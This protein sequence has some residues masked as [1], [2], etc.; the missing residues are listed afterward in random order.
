M[1]IDKTHEYLKYVDDELNRLW[2]LGRNAVVAWS[3]VDA[4]LEVLTVPQYL[5][6]NLF[7]N[8]EEILVGTEQ[9]T[10]EE[11]AEVA[12]ICEIEP[13]RIIVPEALR[14]CYAGDQSLE[15]LMRR[16]GITKLTNRAVIL[17]DIVGFSHYSP[18]EQVTALNSLSYSIN[19]AYQRAIEHGLDVSLCYSTTGDGFYVW[20]RSDGLDANVDVFCFLMLVLADNSLGRRKGIVTTIPEL[21]SG[22]NIGDC[23]EYFQAEGARPGTGSYIVGDA[24][25]EL[26]R[27]VEKA[28]PYQILIGDFETDADDT[29]STG[30]PK[31]SAPR[32]L[33]LA[34]ARLKV[35]ENVNLSRE[36]V[37]SIK[38]YLTGFEQDNGSY[39]VCRYGFADKHGFS[40]KVYNA[41]V[42]VHRAN[43]SEIF[44]GRMTGDLDMFDADRIDVSPLE[45]GY[46]DILTTA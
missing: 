40:H 46:D 19:V 36:K 32:F 17:F 31:Y 37:A 29:Q 20:N 8:H 2:R 21:R 27:I 1:A 35:F 7:A 41:K 22:F 12:D 9:R 6:P 15:Y 38:C 44:L 43:G 14:D 10:R 33:Q 25:I 4:G 45:D 30:D 3:V 11:L 28:M 42:N 16:F 23:Y 24:T 5:L 13:Y 39:N 26:A 18:L 34:Q